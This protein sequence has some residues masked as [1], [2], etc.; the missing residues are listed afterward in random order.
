MK[1]AP[2]PWR[3]DGACFPPINLGEMDIII[4][5]TSLSSNIDV[6]TRLP[7]ST[8]TLDISFFPSQ[9][10]TSFK[11]KVCE[12]REM[13]STPFL[14]KV[15][16]FFWEAFLR[17]KTIIFPWERVERILAPKGKRRWESRITRTIFFPFQLGWRTVSRGSS[18]ISV[19]I[20]TI[21]T[22]YSPL[23]R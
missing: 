11:S 8:S 6:S 1:S 22:S 7:P 19:F 3:R 23:K 16:A 2:S 18:L 5:S 17:E 15:S 4:L 14:R 20:P 13:T 10:R 21:S 9:D 12:E